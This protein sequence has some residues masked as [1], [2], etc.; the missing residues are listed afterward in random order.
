MTSSTHNYYC[1]IIILFS[2]N[3]KNN[4]I[5]FITGYD[6]AAFYTFPYVENMDEIGCVLVKHDCVWQ[7]KDKKKSLKGKIG[8]IVAEIKQPRLMSLKEFDIDREK[9]L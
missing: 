5:A 1:F 9:K 8:Q 6:E 2:F 4:L 3:V 7:Q